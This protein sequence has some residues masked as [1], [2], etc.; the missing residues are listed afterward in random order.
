MAFAIDDSR[1]GGCFA[2][3]GDKFS[4]PETSTPRGR[5]A[6]KDDESRRRIDQ[7]GHTGETVRALPVVLHL[8]PLA[9]WISGVGADAGLRRRGKSL[10]TGDDD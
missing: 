7:R 8:I 1:C 9:A 10:G 4:L 3:R 5:T 2:L 6:K